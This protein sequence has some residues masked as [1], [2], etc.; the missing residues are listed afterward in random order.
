MKQGSEMGRDGSF[1]WETH[2][3]AFWAAFTCLRKLEHR[4][5]GSE[6]HALISHQVGGEKACSDRT[7]P[8]QQR[9]WA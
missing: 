1:S 9:S 8:K 7:V 4:H 3:C 5:C 6:L 2:C